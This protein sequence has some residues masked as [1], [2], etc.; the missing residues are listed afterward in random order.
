MSK[1]TSFHELLNSDNPEDRMSHDFLVVLL[2]E[3]FGKDDHIRID[4]TVENEKN[5]Q[6]IKK[7]WKQIREYYGVAD[8]V[9][10]T[11]KRVRQTM[12]QIVSHINKKYEFSQPLKL[13]RK[14]K[15]CYQKGKGNVSEYWIDLS[16]V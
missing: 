1:L 14:R 12:I 11:Q 6:V 3:L 10:Y 9:K 5:H 13:E 8:S 7:N 4:L 16:L 2:T 15:D